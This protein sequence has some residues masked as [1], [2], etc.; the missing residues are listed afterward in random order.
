MVAALQVLGTEGDSNS[1]NIAKELEKL[2]K[3]T[4]KQ[5]KGWLNKLTH[6][7]IASVHTFFLSNTSQYT[8]MNICD[9][10]LIV[11]VAAKIAQ[12]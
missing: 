5:T 3:E 11:A 10:L 8:Y 9:K 2:L 7:Q 1:D 4:G 12:L 6:Y